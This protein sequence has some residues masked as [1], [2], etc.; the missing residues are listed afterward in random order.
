L[1]SRRKGRSVNRS[2][3]HKSP[4]RL[5]S[6]LLAY[7]YKLLKAGQPVAAGYAEH[8]ECPFQSV[9]QIEYNGHKI[10]VHTQYMN[11]QTNH[12]HFSVHVN[13]ALR[14]SATILLRFFILPILYRSR[15]AITFFEDTVY[16]FNNIFERK[17][18]FYAC[19]VIHTLNSLEWFA[20]LHK[21]QL[22][23]IIWFNDTLRITD[24][25]LVARKEIGD[26]SGNEL[27]S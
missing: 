15:Q 17:F 25:K 4:S 13:H 22:Y 5:P 21:F 3:A 18:S 20:R 16:S 24:A 1:A 9:R 2:Y 23:S 12:D 26:Q 7:S 19:P 27:F 8:H 10:V 11:W 14:Y 6:D